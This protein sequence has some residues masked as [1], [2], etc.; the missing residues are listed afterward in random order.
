MTASPSAAQPGPAATGRL[1]MTRTDTAGN[2]G[3]PAHGVDVRDS[4]D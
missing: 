1:G 2:A 3:S 4:R